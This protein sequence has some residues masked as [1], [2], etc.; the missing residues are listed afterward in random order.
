MSQVPLKN[1]H[2]RLP[3]T[4]PELSHGHNVIVYDY[5]KPIDYVLLVWKT[6][7]LDTEP[8]VFDVYIYVCT[9]VIFVRNN[10]LK[11]FPLLKF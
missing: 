11:I 10:Y 6:M 5:M 3:R 4:K 9:Y 7:Y 2:S 1:P 8:D